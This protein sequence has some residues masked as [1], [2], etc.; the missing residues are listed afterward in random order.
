MDYIIFDLEWT[1]NVRKVIPGCPDEII[2]I[3]AVKYDK[4]LKY[5][6]S[7]NRYIKPNVYDGV[8]K[9]VVQ[10]TGITK[11]HLLRFGIPFT[12]AFREFKTFIGHDS[13]LLSW[14]PQD[15]QI[16]RVNAQY[17]DKKTKLN[18]MYRFS[19]LQRYAA[20]RLQNGEKQQMGLKTAADLCNISYDEETLHDAHV[21]AEISGKVF[22][23]VF[24]KKTFPATVR[25][26]SVP[27]KTAEVKEKKPS[28]EAFAL[29]CPDCGRILKNKSGWFQHS[30]AGNFFAFMQCKPCKRMLF[31]T[32]E[33]FRS[34]GGQIHYKRRLRFVD[35]VKDIKNITE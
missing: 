8:D 10:I 15:I 29:K 19:D 24:D 22:A 32:V 21:D 23:E 18:F 26:A 14:G 5:K 27:K 20:E 9:K 13:V 34:K 6:A 30:G 7:F 17:Y 12:E 3:G 11:E 31:A 25:D 16:L 33:T 1:R 28:A 4:N 35:K 2:Q